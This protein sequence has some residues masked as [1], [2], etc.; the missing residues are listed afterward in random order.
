LNS[1]FNIMALPN[2]R[3]PIL[4]A[5]LA[6]ILFLIALVSRSGSVDVSEWKPSKLIPSYGARKSLDD[7]LR[8]SEM[9]WSKSVENRLLM[10][11]SYADPNKNYK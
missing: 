3:V 5:V 8:H 6:C 7:N 9:L 11:K 10:A 1:R 4:A 2:R